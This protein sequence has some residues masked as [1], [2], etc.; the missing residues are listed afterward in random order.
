MKIIILCLTEY[1]NWNHFSSIP[2]FQRLLN[3]L[4]IPEIKFQSRKKTLRF[5]FRLFLY[6]GSKK[7]AAFADLFS[8]FF[9][10]VRFPRISRASNHSFQYESKSSSPFNYSR[11]PTKLNSL[12]S[13][14]PSRPPFHQ[15]VRSSPFIC[16]SP[17]PHS[18]LIRK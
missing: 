13:K 11:I 2:S 12:L 10:F 18:S 15:T 3:F 5:Y 17:P 16:M 8:F 7:R 6:K 4:Y 1:N 9:F 14:F